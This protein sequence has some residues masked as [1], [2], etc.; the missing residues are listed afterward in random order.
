MFS[1]QK[2]L[3]IITVILSLNKFRIQFYTF[4]IL[5]E[6]LRE[7][8]YDVNFSIHAHHNI[9]WSEKT[10]SYYTCVSLSYIEIFLVSRSNK[11][12][13]TNTSVGKICK[14][15]HKYDPD[16]KTIHCPN[17]LLKVNTFYFNS[18]KRV[19]YKIQPFAN[20]IDIEK[21]RWTCWRRSNILENKMYI[22]W[23]VNQALLIRVYKWKSL[24]LWFSQYS[25]V[26][27][28]LNSSSAWIRLIFKALYRIDCIYCT[29]DNFGSRNQYAMYWYFNEIRTIIFLLSCS[30]IGPLKYLFIT[31][32]KLIN[33]SFTS[34]YTLL[35]LQ[36]VSFFARRTAVYKDMSFENLQFF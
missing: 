18:W 8:L 26:L 28:Q 2:Q 19:K 7:T 14:A 13:T 25:N 1:R 24:K 20:N 11:E 30:T 31:Q 21:I 15:H 16:T 10:F 32:V 34:L 3:K 36:K 33:L 35:C 9:T 29:Y 12:F 27:G 17:Y 5:H 23:V 4:Q 6:I 22:L